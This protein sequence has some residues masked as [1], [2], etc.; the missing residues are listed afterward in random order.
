MNYSNRILTER[1]S[2]AKTTGRLFL[3]REVGDAKNHEKKEQTRPE[4]CIFMRLKLNTS[5]SRLNS[6]FPRHGASNLLA[7]L[8][9]FSG[10]DIFFC[11]ESSKIPIHCTTRKLLS[12][13]GRVF[14]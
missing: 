8:L 13:H 1:L 7:G 3:T 2:I 9:C 14:L 12:C 10:H 4:P 11:F 5:N 6:H